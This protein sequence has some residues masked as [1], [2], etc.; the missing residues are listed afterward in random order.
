MNQVVVAQLASAAVIGAVSPVATMATIAVLTGGR[1]PVLNALALLT[2]WSVV[3]VALAAVMR[4]ALGDS[5]AALNDD[6]KAVLNLIIGQLLLSFGLRQVIGGRHPLA[7]AVEGG[8]P[9]Q[10]LKPPRWMQMLDTL[11]PPKALAIGAVL[12]LVSPADLAVYLSAVQGIRGVDLSDGGQILVNAALIAAIDLCILV[13]LAIYVLMPRRAA[14]ILT[15]LRTWL[16]ANQRKVVAWV[17]LV[18]GALLFLSALGH[19]VG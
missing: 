3:L 13:P 12:L 2:G 11:T 10:A 1:R 16:I 14:H 7:H 4:L 18:F 5:G 9:Q 6:T 15:A 19:L 17:L 8:T